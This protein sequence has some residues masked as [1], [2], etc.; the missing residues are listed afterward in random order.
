MNGRCSDTA[1]P[2]FVMAS[3]CDNTITWMIRH[4]RTLCACG[5]R[6]GTATCT[7]HEYM[8]L[9]KG[10]RVPEKT[11]TAQYLSGCRCVIFEFPLQPSFENRAELKYLGKQQRNQNCMHAKIQG[12]LNSMPTLHHYIQDLSSS[13]LLYKNIRTNRIMTSPVVLHGCETWSLKLQKKH[14]LRAFKNRYWGRSLGL[15]GGNRR[16]EK[17]A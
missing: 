6:G 7:G 3:V 12:R 1:H 2:N 16:L 8:L 11:E 14:G 9:F 13:Y 17:T 10:G 15:R 5:C 4:Y